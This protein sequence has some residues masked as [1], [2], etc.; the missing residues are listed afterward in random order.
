MADKRFGVMAALLASVA[1]AMAVPAHA[2]LTGGTYHVTGDGLR[3]G[4]FEWAMS[5][6]GAGC[7]S[8]DGGAHGQLHRQGGGWSGT[9]NAGCATTID[10]GALTGTYHCPMI[11]P[12][13]IQLTKTG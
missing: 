12:I 13:A 7:L 4:G 9:T 3:D 1:V 5:S 10:D 11:A 6:C 8:I 2:E